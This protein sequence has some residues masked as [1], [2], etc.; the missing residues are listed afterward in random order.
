MGPWKHRLRTDVIKKIQLKQHSEGRRLVSFRHVTQTG[1][2][3]SSYT[4]MRPAVCVIVFIHPHCPVIRVVVLVMS[5]KGTRCCVA[6]PQC[7]SPLPSFVFPSLYHFFSVLSTPSWAQ[8]RKFVS[9]C[10][11]SC[12]QDNSLNCWLEGDDFI[13]RIK[14]VSCSNWDFYIFNEAWL[15]RCHFQTVL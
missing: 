10:L 2:Y 14:P 15:Q 3:G 5:M 12:F 8:C 13:A 4:G 7:S 6:L 11:H 1:T 9:D